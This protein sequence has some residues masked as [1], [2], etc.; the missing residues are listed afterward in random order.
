M[1]V[2]TIAKNSV[3]ISFLGDSFWL[4]RLPQN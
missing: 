1:L 3:S 4:Y 2:L